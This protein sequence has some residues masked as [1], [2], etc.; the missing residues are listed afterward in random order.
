MPVGFDNPAGHWILEHGTTALLAQRTAASLA[1]AI[2]TLVEDRA[3]RDELADNGLAR[4]DAHHSDWD[5]AFEPLWS[6]LCDP[7]TASPR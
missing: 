6:H 3:Q 4:I 2:G 7:E 1:D 5:V